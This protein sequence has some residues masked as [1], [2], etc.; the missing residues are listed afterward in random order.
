M[1]S[2]QL[3]LQVQRRVTRTIS[4]NL[5]S[6]MHVINSKA[7]AKPANLLFVPSMLLSGLCLEC[8]RT[9]QQLEVT[10]AGRHNHCDHSP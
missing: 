7:V 3:Q 6:C 1:Y 4:H 5:D 10:Q 8:C 9:C 2:E